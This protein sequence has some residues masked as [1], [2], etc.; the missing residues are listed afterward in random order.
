MRLQI[1]SDAHIDYPGARGLP[2][3]TAGARVVVVAGDTCEGL[4]GAVSALRRK[5]PPS[6]EIVVVAGNHEFFGTTWSDE[7]EAGK[8]AALR[9]GIHLLENDTVT[10]GR[11]R[12]IGATLWTDYELFG[13]ELR[14]PAM[15]TAQHAMI[16]H[17]RI[18]WQQEPSQPF[19]PNQA[20][21]L[22]RESRAFIERELAKPH[23]GPTLVLTH[24]A[25]CL[26]AIAP[27]RNNDILSAA[28]GS[29]LLT[30]IDRYQPDLWVSGHTHFSMNL[31]R[32][33]TR[34]ISNPI[35]YG[36]E[37][38]LFDPLFRVDIDA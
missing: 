16:D 17:S 1:F 6:A 31:K 11:L 34:L 3:L 12:V 37:N 24:H 23:E 28:Y 21:I 7:L 14:A 32:G 27:F 5:Y 35:G 13:A 10:V 22:H 38:P 19:L 25:P 9:L 30:I 20:Q 2:P 4:I 18:V 29:D 26:E 33:R 15:R 8:L 36:D